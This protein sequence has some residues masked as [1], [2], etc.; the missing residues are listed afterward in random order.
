MDT[1]WSSHSNQLNLSTS[2]NSDDN[3]GA[4]LPIER[5]RD[6]AL[7]YAADSNEPPERRRAMANLFAVLSERLGASPMGEGVAIAGDAGV[8]ASS[9]CVSDLVG[10]TYLR[11]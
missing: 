1:V 6:V 4:R 8:D 3:R 9:R 7:R 10:D 5:T 2:L 11:R